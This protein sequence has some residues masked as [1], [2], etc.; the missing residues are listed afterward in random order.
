M[1]DYAK[2]QGTIEFIEQN[3]KADINL[4]VV[5]ESS[6]YSVPHFY[7]LFSAIVKLPVME[8][9]RKRKLSMAMRDI[10]LTKRRILDIALD[11]G[12][13]SYGTFLRAFSLMYQLPP[14]VCRKTVNYFQKFGKWKW[15]RCIINM[16]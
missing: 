10:V 5:A 4:A 14:S 1:N 6:G 13:E 16:F 7:R 8:Y 3:L 15:Y 12:F 9:I 11:Y 2:I